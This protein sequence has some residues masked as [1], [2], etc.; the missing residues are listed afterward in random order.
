M[1]Q[2]KTNKKSTVLKDRADNA[3]FFKIL[4]IVTLFILIL[5]YLMFSRGR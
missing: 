1:T 2:L 3:K 5:L 4:G